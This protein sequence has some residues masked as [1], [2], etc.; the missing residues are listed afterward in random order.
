M[1]LPDT[2][3]KSQSCLTVLECASW[4]PNYSGQTV[5]S[6]ITKTK[7]N[8]IKAHARVISKN[9]LHINSTSRRQSTSTRGSKTWSAL[10]YNR[11]RE[12]QQS[13]A[14]VNTITT[15]TPQNSMGTQ[16]NRTREYG[17]TRRPRI[18]LCSNGQTQ[19]ARPSLAPSPFSVVTINL[20]RL[21]NTFEW[22]PGTSL[23]TFNSMVTCHNCSPAPAKTSW[24]FWLYQQ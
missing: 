4:L 13:S 6:K 20:A 14:N 5:P 22:Q 15:M 12:R 7:L 18:M 9:F 8:K 17:K 10:C 19:S 11:H 23:A 21:P 1:G 3:F 24:P 2:A 16:C